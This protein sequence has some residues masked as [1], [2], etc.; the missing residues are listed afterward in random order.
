MFYR[1]GIRRTLVSWTGNL[2]QK[3]RS[4]SEIP[5]RRF[6]RRETCV[7]AHTPAIVSGCPFGSADE[8]VRSQ[9]RDGTWLWVG[10]LKSKLFKLAFGFVERH[11][12]TG[13][14]NV[15]LNASV[16]LSVWRAC[17]EASCVAPSAHK[18]CPSVFSMPALETQWDVC[19][20]SSHWD[21][22]RLWIRRQYNSTASMC[23]STESGTHSERHPLIHKGRK[24]CVNR[25][26]GIYY[27]QKDR[28]TII[29]SLKSLKSSGLFCFLEEI[30]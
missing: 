8:T 9:W 18:H 7:L 16:P 5:C 24:W 20:H 4:L 17:G 15:S 10:R 1:M 29:F 30:H 26:S 11:L 12:R 21:R 14:K 2:Q 23:N 6:S 22:Q 13:W 19:L 3:V 28:F 27:T 25:Q